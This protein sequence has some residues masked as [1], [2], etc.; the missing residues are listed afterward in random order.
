MSLNFNATNCILD[1]QH[2]IFSAT[3]IAKSHYSD[4]TVEI[5]QIKPYGAGTFAGNLFSTMRKIILLTAACLMLTFSKALAQCDCDFIISLSSSE[6]QF[7]GAKKGVKPGDKICLTSGVRTGFGFFNI[8][9]TAANPVIIT[10]MCDGKV[11]LNAP[12]NWGNAVEIKNSS[13]F[14]FTGSGN[15]SINTGI[16]II[17]AQMG[18]NIYER[19]TDFEVDHISVSNAGCVGV[20]AKTDPTCDSKT[21]RGNFTMRNTSFH[22]ILVQNTGCEGFYIGNSHYETGVTKTCNGSNIK[23]NEHDVVNVKVYNNQVKNT[24]NDGIQ[25]GGAISGAEIHHNKVYNFGTA[26]TSGHMNGV[27]AGS[28]TT[29][30]KIY[31]NVIDTGNGYC[32]W[33]QG[34]GSTYYDN[35]ANKGALGGFSLQDVAGTHAT[36]GFFV[37]NNT[38]IDCN[39]LGIIMYSENPAIT[40]ITNNIIYSSLSGYNFIKYNSPKAQSLTIESNNLK[41]ASLATIKFSNPSAKDYHLLSGSPAIDQGKDLRTLG[42]SIDLDGK[43]RPSGASFDI[44]AYEYTSS[45]TPANVVP[46]ASAGAD[47]SITLPIGA[48]TLTG[49][50]SDSDGTIASYTWTKVSGPNVVLSNTNTSILTVTSLL[51]G[52]YTYRLTVKDNLGATAFD[53]VNLTVQALGS[54]NSSPTANAGADKTITLPT[55]AITLT[56]SATD[57]DGT[58]S[59]YSWSK[60]SG[61]TVTL[62]NTTTANLT[63]SNLLSGRYVF[64]LTVTDN[65]GAVDTDDILVVAKSGTVARFNFT[66]VKQNIAGWNDLAGSPHSSV[67]SA[68]DAASNVKVSSVST[69]Q[70]VPA[71]YGVLTTSYNGGVKDGN[72]QPATVMQTNWFNYNAPYGAT[73]NGVVQGNN[74]QISNLDP[75]HYYTITVGASRASGS[76]SADQYGTFEYRLNGSAIKTL[77]VTDNKSTQVEY[78]NVKPNASGVVG[79]SARKISGSSMNFGYI[80]WLVITDVTTAASSITSQAEQ[81]FDT[82]G[83]APSVTDDFVF[84]DNTLPGGYNYLVVLYN[85]Q[86]ERIFHG[87]WTEDLYDQLIT[88][89]ELYIYHI[90]RDGQQI[91]SGK[92]KRVN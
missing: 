53:D 29:R 15:S 45:T 47:K 59:K 90:L 20:V 68:T 5:K 74:I 61:G 57:K 52:T 24:A 78:A 19:S 2:S 35:I 8:N 30:A 65:K 36:T 51:A 25:V 33:D 88:E 54:T 14:R 83:V 40:T 80:G 91:N 72:I 50:G 13:F 77:S 58:I 27:Q 37:A 32:F 56:G 84:M 21:W 81:V 82:L 9:G 63:V 87:E 69:G 31:Q 75:T 3:A 1:S 55:S 64:R 79:L 10:N 42:V 76:G 48:L 7:D 66:N 22:D 16:E 34:G 46:K 44:G 71:N 39:A 49:S 92:I 11:T 41:S 73:I 4:V 60:V 38:I 26:K 43:S 62:S 6:Y 89:G 23:V 85:G 28:G 12:S 70:W 86:G 67:I 18:L 17:G